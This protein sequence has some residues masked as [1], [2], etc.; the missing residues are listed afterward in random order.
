MTQPKKSQDIFETQVKA[1]AQEMLNAKLCINTKDPATIESLKSL[2]SKQILTHDQAELK[3]NKFAEK[4]NIQVKYFVIAEKKQ[5]IK[6]PL[7]NMEKNSA[8]IIASGSI[9]FLPEANSV[10]QVVGSVLLEPHR[11]AFIKD[12]KDD[13][14]NVLTYADLYVS[15]NY[16]PN[17]YY[18]ND[19]SYFF[20]FSLPEKITSTDKK[21]FFPQGDQKSCFA[22]NLEYI[23]VL[24]SNE[25]YNL[26]NKSF[27]FELVTGSKDGLGKLKNET[28]RHFI[29]CAEVLKYSQSDT[30]NEAVLNFVLCEEQTCTIRCGTEQIQMPSLFGFLSKTKNILTQRK[31]AN[32]AS[33]DKSMEELKQFRQRFIKDYKDIVLPY[34][35]IHGKQSMENELSRCMFPIEEDE[36]SEENECVGEKLKK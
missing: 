22:F 16:Y 8:L 4:H 5:S 18:N 12:T 7:L 25:Q 20:V 19:I 30:Y 15:E 28:T 11:D 6:Q 17:K 35:K 31:D 32:V 21:T 24:L 13:I 27:K 1:L 14:I 33:V 23:K 34:R 26:K 3:V 29:P 9:G 2:V 36:S 10:R